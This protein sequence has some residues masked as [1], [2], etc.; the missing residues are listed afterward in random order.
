[1]LFCLIAILAV[2][3]VLFLTQATGRFGGY[4]I[5]VHFKDTNGLAPGGEVLL[6]GVSVGKVA[7]V[8]LA[9]DRR[10]PD[11]PV[12]VTL[13]MKKDIALYRTDEFVID[14]A[15]LLGDRFVSVKRPSDR[16]LATMQ[17]HRGAPIK[18]TGET[19]L[20]GGPM[21]G[22]SNLS[23]Q[24]QVL[25]TQMQGAIAAVTATYASPEMRR[26]LTEFLS[27]INQAS[28]QLQVISQSAVGL[29]NTLNHLIQANQGAV[30]SA[31]NNIEAATVSMRGAAAQV[32]QTL[33]A[34]TT[35]PV[36]AQL[37]ATV[38]NIRTTSDEIRAS[39]ES[40]H[41]MISNPENQKRLQSALQDVAQATANMAAMSENMKKMTGDQKMQ[42]DIRATMDNL[43]VSTDNLREI[44]EASKQIMTSK[45]N[46]EAI[47]ETLANMAAAT[48]GAVNLTQQAGGT[49]ERVNKTMGQVSAITGAF[50]PGQT[51]G[52]A[53]LE[54]GRGDHVR[55]DVNLDLA[56]SSD[57]Y[58]F[59]RVGVRDLG[60]KETLNL[61]RALRV[62]KH[63]YA[64][65][66][67]FGN[68][69]GAG[70]DWEWSPGDVVEL[71]AWHPGVNRLDLRT[72]WALLDRF[73]LTAG[74]NRLFDDNDPFVGLQ[75]D[76]GPKH[77]PS[78]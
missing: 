9:S 36:P 77:K 11:Q 46:L 15:S 67:I 32:N 30:T 2:V 38:A 25:M 78:K 69:P 75:W 16:E 51:S 8:E 20:S 50:V 37:L 23:D 72:Y 48:K 27:R 64:R 19:D 4:H 6:D 44:T 28:G 56:W 3:V 60:G 76:L 70:V 12:A 1:M 34:I 29:I 65:A 57:P 55:A 18:T 7:Q 31:V 22:L 58:N 47:N 21:I 74:V 39:A 41:A 53:R 68:S 61:Q 71:E 5:V 17:V 45:Q 13:A 33:H 66:G 35:G 10:F 43:K 52:F 54:A 24:V 26:Q 62:G 49:L 14:Q 42:A 59:L 63:V 73:D 40:I